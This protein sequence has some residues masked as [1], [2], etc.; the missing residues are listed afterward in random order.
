MSILTVHYKYFM[1]DRT[2]RMGNIFTDW[3]VS[4]QQSQR[5]LPCLCSAVSLDRHSLRRCGGRGCICPIEYISQPPQRRKRCSECG[6]TGASE[7]TRVY[8][9]SVLLQRNETPILFTINKYTKF[10]TARGNP[11]YFTTQYKN[12]VLTTY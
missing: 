7:R 8:T 1:L 9:M 11:T 3:S 4:L 10:C 12:N 5:S 6:V 2:R